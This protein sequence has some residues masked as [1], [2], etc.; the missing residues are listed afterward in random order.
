MLQKYL[1]LYHYIITSTRM[2]IKNDATSG[3]IMTPHRAAKNNSLLWS[4]ESKC[5]F[6]N[7][8]QQ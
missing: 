7:I 6:A 2:G 4:D 8:F 5:A 3:F 1:K